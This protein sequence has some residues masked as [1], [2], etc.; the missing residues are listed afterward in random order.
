MLKEKLD[1][2]KHV[3]IAQSKIIRENHDV[4]PRLRTKANDHVTN[5]SDNNK[6]IAESK[7]KK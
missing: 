5:A 7:E 1:T 2:R 3:Q 4:K 6:V